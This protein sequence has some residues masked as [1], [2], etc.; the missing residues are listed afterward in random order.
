MTSA[1]I[2][3]NESFLT[4]YLSIF[5]S[6]P[7]VTYPPKKNYTLIYNFPAKFPTVRGAKWC[8]KLGNKNMEKEVH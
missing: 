2:I 6:C 1:E 3:L 4:F 7:L 8:C 5:L